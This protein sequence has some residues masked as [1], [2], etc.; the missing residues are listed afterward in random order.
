MAKG[1]AC[2]GFF[3][4]AL[5]GG[6][7]PAAAAEFIVNLNASASTPGG[8]GVAV[9][10]AERGPM[11]LLRSGSSTAPTT[12]D[13]SAAAGAFGWAETGAVHARAFAGAAS[14]SPFCCTN[15][16]AAASAYVESSDFLFASA[17]GY[18]AGTE[19]LI[20]TRVSVSGNSGVVGS[21][22][23]WSGSS[24][25]RATGQINN[26]SFVKGAIFSADGINGIT[27]DFGDP[28]GSFLQTFRIVL[29][30][31]NR[32]LLRGE[33]WASGNAGGFGANS[34]G[35][36]ANLGRTIAWGG[37]ESMTIGGVLVTDFTAYSPDTG[38]DFKRGYLAAG[39]VPEP[40]TWA[41]LVIGFGTLGSAMRRRRSRRATSPIC[42]S[43]G[44]GAGRSSLA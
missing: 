14:G 42:G 41:M 15:G 21:G 10:T 35:A 3:T 31:N 5:A 32:V 16:Q 25:W 33:T 12:A 23:F 28:L 27:Q 18:A 44:S 19:A 37:I 2:V 26:D 43:L 8:N 36:D 24:S 29:G 7:Q 22:Q 6:A 39:A 13:A 20:V 30:Q 38:F 4:L 1:W 9:N 11:E 17:G 40:G 34:V